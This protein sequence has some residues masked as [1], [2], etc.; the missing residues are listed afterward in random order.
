M[1]KMKTSL[2]LAALIL[3]TG[4]SLITSAKQPTETYCSSRPN[5][6]GGIATPAQFGCVTQGVTICCYRIPDNFVITK[7]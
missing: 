2:A 3:S 6:Q 4:I 1:K 7:F 5:G